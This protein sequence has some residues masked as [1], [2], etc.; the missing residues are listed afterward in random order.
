MSLPLETR[1]EATGFTLIPRGTGIG[2]SATSTGSGPCM[3]PVTPNGRSSGNRTHVSDKH[4][5]AEQPIDQLTAARR[6]RDA[7]VES[8]LDTS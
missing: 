2:E 4:T 5:A 8:M 1:H 7:F 6:C 3:F